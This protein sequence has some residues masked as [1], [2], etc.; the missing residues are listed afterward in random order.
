MPPARRVARSRFAGLSERDL[1]IALFHAGFAPARMPVPGGPV[2]SSARERD[3]V[4]FWQYPCLTEGAAWEQH[5]DLAEPA[6]VDGELHLYLG[7]PWATWIDFSRKMAWPTGGS[8]A[9]AQQ[10]QMMKV[11]LSGLRGAL[12]DLDIGLRVHTVCQH[13]YWNDMSDTWRQLGVTDVWLSHCPIY[14]EVDQPKQRRTSTQLGFAIHPWALFAVNVRD[15]T[16]STGIVTGRDPA[17]KT[18]LASFIG[19]HAHHYLSDTRLRLRSLENL[20]DFHIR[21]TDHWHF[22]NVVYAEQ[23]GGQIPAELDSD[24]VTSYNTILSDS[25][26]S[27]CPAGAGANTLRLWESLAVGAIPV[28]CGPQPVLPSGGNLPVIDWE[29]IVVRIPDE[30]ITNL[31]SILRAIPISELRSRQQLGMQAYAQIIVQRCF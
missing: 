21:V 25:V 10:L 30:Q 23:I 24:S 18:V 20:Y 17:S 22:E 2:R 27:L 16:R 6:L 13:I 12:E 19:T 4:L 26:F 9:M 1:Q 15:A 3:A 28:L 5:A 7:L 8:A 14:R 29:R 11:R 31:P